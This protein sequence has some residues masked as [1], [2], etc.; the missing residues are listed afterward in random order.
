MGEDTIGD[1]LLQ[2]G[3]KKDFLSKKTVKNKGEVQQY[4]VE[5]DHAA[6]VSPEVFSAVQADL[7]KRSKEGKVVSGKSIYSSKV[8]CSCCDSYYGSQIWHSNTIHR[9]L[10]YRCN[11]TYKNPVRCTTPA[12]S[13]AD[14]Q[15]AFIEAVNSFVDDKA[16]IIA[17]LELALTA[18]GD[19]KLLN[20]RLLKVNKELAGL[21]EEIQTVVN[22]GGRRDAD[23]D[24]FIE[25]YDTLIKV[26][27]DTKIEAENLEQEID[28]KIT[29]KLGIQSTIKELKGIDDN[30]TEFDEAL[31]GALL[32]HM[33]VYSK[34]KILVTFRGGA[35]VEVNITE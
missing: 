24:E 33:T 10:M 35:E 27:E 1:A 23:R 17:N 18:L 34:Q 30:I 7:K 20:D 4:Y 21:V 9:K 2:K 14:M 16:E 8:I 28:A 22:A 6:I 5:N 32:D 19:T 3:Y 31:W 26:Y 29:K 12:L 15:L 13:E 25:K 11:H